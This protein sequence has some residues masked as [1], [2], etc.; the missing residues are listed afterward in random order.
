MLPSKIFEIDGKISQILVYPCQ[1]R[2]IK[3]QSCKLK[4][5]QDLKGAWTQ[6]IKKERCIDNYLNKN[7]IDNV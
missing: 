4:E 5:I 2:G 6:L 1:V 7:P 3:K